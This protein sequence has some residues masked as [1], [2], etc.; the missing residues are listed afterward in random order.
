MGRLLRRSKLERT[1]AR[2]THS[3]GAQ[4]ADDGKVIGARY[5]LWPTCI[6]CAGRDTMAIR[7]DFPP[8][9]SEV[10][11]GSSDG[12][13]Y[14]TTFQGTTLDDTLAM[15]RTFLTEEGYADVP[16]PGTAREM[17]AFLHPER[18][19]HPHLFERPDYSHMPVRLLLPSRDR[20]RRKLIVEL[21]NEAAPDYLLRF[22]RRQCPEREA[23]VRAAIAAHHLEQVGPYLSAPARR[24]RV[25]SA[26]S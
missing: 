19:R 1:L 9:G 21:Y 13:V 10:L 15:V 22:H 26:A 3:A 4:L 7:H 25:G 11:G 12:L 2:P 17:L 16:L 20:L 14:T 6:S 23:H 8:Y 24:A 18:G 5:E